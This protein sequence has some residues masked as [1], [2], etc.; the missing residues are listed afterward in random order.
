MNER[1][2]AWIVVGV[3]LLALAYVAIILIGWRVAQRRG[4]VDWQ[5][6]DVQDRQD[7]EAYAAVNAH[8]D[9]PLRHEAAT[10]EEMA[11]VVEAAECGHFDRWETELLCRPRIGQYERRM[12]GA[13]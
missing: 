5:A 11:A 2:I 3:S 7:G 1:V 13:G 12:D 10:D 6:V 4:D 8:L 9:P